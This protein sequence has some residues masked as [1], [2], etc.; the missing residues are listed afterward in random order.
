MATVD[1]SFP[2]TGKTVPLD[3]GY[4]LYAAVTTRLPDLHGARWLGIHPISGQLVDDQ[5][6]LIRS[7]NLTLR[8]PSERITEVLSLAGA[9]L[10]VGASAIS[11]GAPSIRALV[12]A[13]ALDARLV[14]LKLTQPPTREN[15]GLQR[16]VLDNDVIADRYRAELQRQL[17]AMEVSAAI[18]LCGRRTITIKGKRLI[19]YSVRLTGL[20]ADASLRVQERGLG[21]RRVLGCGLFRP[22]RWARRP[23]HSR[24]DTPPAQAE[25]TRL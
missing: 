10:D 18:E 12:P 23:K 21:G 5:I 3:H 25:E 9:R 13:A 11:L 15:V 14:L 6:H 2:L 20:D 8:L 16:N 19:G 1:L 4:R 22:T 17:Q 24:D 7:S